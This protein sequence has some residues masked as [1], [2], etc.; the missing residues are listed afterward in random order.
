LKGREKVYFVQVK[1]VWTAGGVV[2]V[3]VKREKIQ[4]R[5]NLGIVFCTFNTEEGEMN[6]FLWFIPANDF[7]KGANYLKGYDE[8]AFTAG[9]EQRE[10]N[11]WN[12]YL[13]DKRDL[14]NQII[15]QMKR[16]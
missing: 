7:I 16:I 3:V 1:S 10:T 12:E 11:K 13:I 8:Y 2:S 14:G 4:N 15:A 6:D 5:K 9:R